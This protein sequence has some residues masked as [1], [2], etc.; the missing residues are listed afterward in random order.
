MR[1]LTGRETDAAIATDPWQGLLTYTGLGHL[2]AN[3]F[4]TQ[5]LRKLGGFNEDYLNCN[6][7]ELFFRL[8]KKGYSY[9]KDQTPGAVLIH[10]A[11]SRITNIDR[12]GMARQRLKLTNRMI[13]CLKIDHPEYYR[14]H[15]RAVNCGCYRKLQAL[16]S[17]RG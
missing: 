9:A 4:R 5:S 8:M 15:R 13:D 7:Y 16:L 12:A 17:K 11:G 1:S 3:L 14:E 10:H 6:D 2:D